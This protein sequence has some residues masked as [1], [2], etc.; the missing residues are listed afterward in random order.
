MRFLI[1]L[2]MLQFV[3]Y[4]F[5]Q[6]VD[7]IKKANLFD[8][9]RGYMEE[10]GEEID[11]EKEVKLPVDMPVLD[12]IAIIGNYKKAIFTYYDKEKRKKVSIYHSVGDK[13]ANASLKEITPEY[14]ILFFDGKQY[15]LYPD[16][17]LKAKRSGSRSAAPVM[18]GYTPPPS[19]N[20]PVT[21]ASKVISRASTSAKKHV[22]PKTIRPGGKVVGRQVTRSKVN[23]ARSVRPKQSNIK[24]NVKRQPINSKGVSNPFAGGRAKTTPTKKGQSGRKITPF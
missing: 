22:R 12:G 20:K 4:G 19:A 13:F 1:A 10:T 14:V 16:T 17:K 11:T 24:R 18:G 6:N 7:L 21:R 8:E 3:F 23:Q 9:N 15:K 2:V 5:S